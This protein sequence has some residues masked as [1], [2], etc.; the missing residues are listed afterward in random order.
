MD[1]MDKQALKERSYFRAV[2][3]C[4][5]KA[6]LAE[7]MG[8]KPD[9]IYK[10]LE[11]KIVPLELAIAF[12]DATGI[13]RLCFLGRDLKNDSEKQEKK[14]KKSILIEIPCAQIDVGTFKNRRAIAAPERDIIIDSD[15]VLI[16]GSERLERHKADM[17]ITVSVLILDLES[18]LL[19]RQNLKDIPYCFLLTELFDIGLRFEQWMGHHPGARHDLGPNRRRKGISPCPALDEVIGRKDTHIAKIL[20]LGSKSTYHNLK[21]VCRKGVFELIQALNEGKIAI[22]TAARM[23]VHPQAQQFEQLQAYLHR[24]PCKRS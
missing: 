7:K 12:E 24:S 23:A 1:Q 20:G 10:F 13:N 19:E 21:T 17:K 3:L 18:L 22:E 4:G 9:V 2:H 15:A 14:T 5:T 8:V 16:S 11:L 6:A